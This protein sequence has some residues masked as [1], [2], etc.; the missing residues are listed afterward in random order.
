MVRCPRRGLPSAPEVPA[1]EGGA[2]DGPRC[3]A[4]AD[5]GCLSWPL[6]GGSAPFASLLDA[7]L[8]E[9]LQA[10][11]AVVAD[12]AARIAVTVPALPT[13]PVVPSPPV[14]PTVTPLP[15]GAPGPVR[16]LPAKDLTS[17][18]RR[19]VAGDTRRTVWTS[20]GNEATVLLDSTRIAT[21][22]GVVL[23][24]LTLDTDQTGP[25]ELTTV[26]A[27]GS[28]KRP[29][30]LL[31]VAEER[32]RGHAD[33]AATFADAV[34]ATAWRGVLLVVAAAAASAGK[35]THGD[36]L[37]PLAL[38]ATADGLFVQTIA[39]HRLGAKR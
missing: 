18:V 11:I 13:P 25:Q 31:V 9:K 4:E 32:P 6:T 16:A 36:P 10:R 19:A 35:D 3:G 2:R 23:V 37:V 20:R 39:D 24:G 26:L 14:P 28:A 8:D 21:D 1:N 29:A 38:T 12:R 33:L 15:P 30:G 22:D 5:V 34:V 17:L 7:H 27:V